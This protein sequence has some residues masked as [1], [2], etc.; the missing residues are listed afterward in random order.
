MK[1]SIFAS[2]LALT[3]LMPEIIPGRIYA[4]DVF[5]RLHFH[6]SSIICHVFSNVKAKHN[7]HNTSRHKNPNRNI[8]YRFAGRTSCKLSP[9]ALNSLSKCT[10]ENVIEGIDSFNVGMYNHSHI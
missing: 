1:T 4:S 10:Y 5:L 7:L 2:S 3:L 6:Y 8:Q 9:S